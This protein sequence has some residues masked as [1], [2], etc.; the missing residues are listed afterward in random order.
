MAESE[1]GDSSADTPMGGTEPSRIG[2]PPAKKQSAA[3]WDSMADHPKKPEV[4][5]PKC[6]T[7][8]CTSCQRVVHPG[9]SCEDAAKQDAAEAGLG[10]LLEKWGVKRCPRCRTAIRHMFGCGHISCRCGANFCFG[11][12]QPVNECA[13]DCDT[14]DLERLE[15]LSAD[16]Y[17]EYQDEDGWPNANH[18][19]PA[20]Q[21]PLAGAYRPATPPIVPR[22]PADSNGDQNA[23]GQRET[24][25][26]FPMTPA[27][28]TAEDSKPEGALYDLGLGA[29]RSEQP[30]PAA[31]LDEHQSSSPSSS[32]DD[33]AHG[34]LADFPTF[35]M[36]DMGRVRRNLHRVRRMARRM[37]RADARRTARAEGRRISRATARAD[38]LT[39]GRADATSARQIPERHQA[40]T[41]PRPSRYRMEPLIRDAEHRRS[42]NQDAEPR[43][44]DGAA[45]TPAPNTRMLLH[46]RIVTTAAPSA[47]A[48]AAGPLRM[49]P[50]TQTVRPDGARRLTPEPLDA[51]WETPRRPRPDPDDLDGQ[52]Q[53]TG[54][55][56]RLDLGREPDGD[57]PNMLACPHRSWEPV[58]TRRLAQEKTAGTS[59]AA[60]ARHL[61]HGSTWEEYRHAFVRGMVDAECSICLGPLASRQGTSYGGAGDQTALAP[62]FPSGAGGATA[63]SGVDWC[64]DQCGVLAC[65][66]CKRFWRLGK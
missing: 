58:D 45:A 55:A 59:G 9:S 32:A 25:H 36:A 8:V 39:N 1:N 51:D 17:G 13:P 64:C 38:M 4:S 3:F 23:S 33:W 66:G 43:G 5:C 16:E 21:T 7:M 40:R 30:L 44:G 42:A 26:S 35:D 18:A 14:T 6:N 15:D 61:P 62:V 37:A 28:V 63:A 10:A 52:L 65:D 49:Y 54:R 46:G 29:D 19:Q 47:L 56:R 31:A 60:T 48:S 41:P 27:S 24:S 11:C 22:R 34:S 50:N 12:L 2:M 20:R 57:A 53:R